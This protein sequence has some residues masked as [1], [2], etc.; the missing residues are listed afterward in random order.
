LGL[1][2]TTSS[3]AKA[4]VHCVLIDKYFDL[5]GLFR[6]FRGQAARL[7]LAKLLQ[8]LPKNRP[9]FY[10]ISS[11]PHISPSTVAITVSMVLEKST[12]GA[13]RRGLCSNYLCESHK[14]QEILAMARQ[15]SFRLPPDPAV[16][17][18]CVGPGTGL[19]PFVGFMEERIV[20][21]RSSVL[22]GRSVV[23]TGAP[24]EEDLIYGERIEE[25]QNA[26]SAV[27]VR[28]ALS[29]VGAKQ[30]VQDLMRKDARDVLG[31][32]LDDGAWLYVCG[33]ACM[34]DGTSDTLMDLIV[35][36]RG[37]SRLAA[38]ELIIGLRDNGR[39][40]SD[41]WGATRFF[42]EGMEWFI[43]DRAPR[44]NRPRY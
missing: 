21:H 39:Y 16:P 38:K 37:L 13:I 30:R 42:S 2:P 41:V 6:A 28:V 17:I 5:A 24:T 35:Q 40:Q 18:I 29:R 8:I 26:C 3:T 9:R 12:Q 27:E 34:A 14:G 1:Q 22:V 44:P 23:F 32:L 11:S 25:W 20:M 4:G 36:E 15:S 31:L 33:D 19:A 7:D 43:S 10:S